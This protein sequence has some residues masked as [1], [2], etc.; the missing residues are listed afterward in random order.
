MREVVTGGAEIDRALLWYDIP[1][2]E[3]HVPLH[4]A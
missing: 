2:V 4:Q 1:L 3:L